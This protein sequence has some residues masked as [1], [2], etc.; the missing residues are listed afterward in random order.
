MRNRKGQ[1]LSAEH[2]SLARGAS[3]PVPGTVFVLALSGGFTLR[4]GRKR[5]VTFG[6]NSEDVHV[7]LGEDDQ[8][9]SRHQGTLTHDRGQWWVSN[10]GRLPIRFAGNR[11]LFRDEEPIPLATGYT[12]CSSAAP[13]TGSTCWRSS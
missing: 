1:P 11:L 10:V 7:C 8:Q 6:R 9:V 13:T 12:R 3:S 5:T 2:G 4:P